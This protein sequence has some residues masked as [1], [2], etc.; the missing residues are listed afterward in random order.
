VISGSFGHRD[1]CA[2]AGIGA[3][4]FTRAS[5]RS[6]VTL[7]TQAALAAIADAGLQVS[8]IDGVVHSDM[9]TVR[10]N[11]L[12][13]S[14]GLDNLTYWGATG[15]GGGAP[16]GMVGQ[17]VGAILSGQATV[18]LVFRS[19]NG[20]SGVRY[21]SPEPTSEAVGGAGTYDEY[22][23]PYGLAAPGQMWALL[24]RRHM[25]EFGTTSAQLGH[26]AVACRAHANAN[27][28]AQ[29]HGRE[30]TVEDHQA[31]RVIS[32]PLRLY[33]YCLE[34]DGACALVVV[35]AERARDTPHPPVLIRAVAQG[36]KRGMQGGLVL[37][38]LMRESLTTQP[39]NQ[40]A[41]TLY[42]RAGLGPDDIDV[43]QIYDC[44]TS[45]VLFQLEDYGFCK[46]GE[47]GPFASSGALRLGGSLP[48]NTAGGNLSE[49]YLHG[50]N[51]ILEGVRQIRGDSTSQVP[52]AETC[53]VTSGLP[54]V[55]SALVLRKG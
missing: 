14:L 19:L 12:A 41:D 27:P 54:I 26:I 23:V 8:D 30:M 10:H 53:L 36:G 17:A 29:M 6:E 2:I 43:A 28:A 35:A 16:C 4:D 42:T 20:R 34:T 1:H 32:D 18:V 33:D 24:A 11:T 21:G 22:F 50:V 5:G 15:T 39:S 47:G 40:V 3:T 45:T 49:G 55:S 52:G 46:K 48:I 9:D 31:S 7:A 51:H 25:H 37:P 38:A 44:F 13:H